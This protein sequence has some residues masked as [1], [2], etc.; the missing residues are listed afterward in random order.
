MKITIIGC[1]MIGSSMAACWAPNH[2]LVL[3]D[4]TFAKAQNLAKVIHAKAFSSA[5]EAVNNSQVILLS[6]KPQNLAEAS[7][8]IY[9]HLKQD[10]LLVSVLAGITLETLTKYYPNAQIIRI[11]P[12]IALRYGQ[13]VIAISDYEPLI[14]FTKEDIQKLFQPMGWIHWINESKMNALSTLSGSGMAFAAT[15]IEASVEAAVAMGLSAEEGLKIILEMFAGTIATLQQS[16]MSPSSLKT[17]VTSPAGT[18]IAG[19]IAMEKAGLRSA[20]LETFLATYQRNK[21]MGNSNS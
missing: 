2:E 18:T 15:I 21:E 10:Q 14:P 20:I 7:E 1:G 19:L 13:G 17:E 16:G 9:K 6:V 3:Y 8:L 4:R 12:N 5:D 11:M